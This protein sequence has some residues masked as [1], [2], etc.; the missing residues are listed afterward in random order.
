MKKD[1]TSSTQGSPDQAPTPAPESSR[2]RPAP[3]P[4]REVRAECEERTP[5]EAGYGYGV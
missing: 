2:Q 1:G 5:E 3:S 4:R